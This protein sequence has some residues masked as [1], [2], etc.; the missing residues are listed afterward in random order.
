MPSAATTTSQ[1][2]NSPAGQ[3]ELEA[4]VGRTARI[5]ACWSPSFSPDGERLAFVS[6]LSGVPQVWTVAAGGGWPEAVTALDDQV[7]S[8]AWSPAGDWLAFSLAPGGGMN[9]QVY[10]VRPDG[11]GLR[12]L[13]A[14]GAETNRLDGWTHDGRALM[15]SSNRRRP[16]AIDSY[17][18]EVA[19]GEW[20][21]VAENPGTGGLSDVSRD[22]RFALLSRL[23]QRGDNNVYLVDLAEGREML[24]TPHEG[25]GSFGPARFS[26]DG[27]SVYLASNRDR[28][29]LALVRL[30]LEGD[31]RPGPLEVLAARD[32]AELEDADL[33]EDGRSAALL[34][35][36]AGRSELALLDLEHGTQ[37]PGP[38]LPAEIAGGLTFSRDGRSLAFVAAGAAAPRD[39]WRLD[40]ADGRLQR[41]TRSPHAGVDLAALIRP[42]LL[43][44]PAH[45]GLELSGWLYR[46]RGAA[47][48]GPIVLSFHGGPE[49]QERPAFNATYQALLAAGI[50]VFAP[51]VRGSSG[52][53]KTF[54]NLDNGP[55]RADGVRDIRACVDCIVRAGVADSR[56]V[57]IMGGSYGGYMTMAGLTEY[58]ELFAAG[59]NLFGIVNFATF[60]AHTEPWMAAISK[61]EYGDPDSQADLLRRL[62]PIHRL[63]RVTAPTLVLH[64][65]NDTNVPVVEAEQTVEHLR[66]RGVP[67]EYVLF[68]DE[69]HGF[70]KAPNRVR[71]TVAIVRWFAQHLTKGREE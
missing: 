25:P 30:R 42:E 48:P 50:A 16:E 36:V 19:G 39:I 5:G 70:R 53:G 37:M 51:N 65:A 62:S 55:L 52:F 67:V 46:P 71:A 49:G 28:E 3:A 63:D 43:R 69:G 20:R 6:D 64:G 23:A 17:L 14:G 27:R 44:F 12:R 56:R 41:V 24:L 4:A 31:G 33:S 47:G 15:L 68:P 57:G 11:G 21:L 29:R 34:W 32:D 40:L 38:T 10:L 9:A 66:Q 60:F 22:G 7:Q 58:P 18:V 1:S 2:G 45:D 8:V 59:A 61:V 13:T 54:V 35:N 26:P